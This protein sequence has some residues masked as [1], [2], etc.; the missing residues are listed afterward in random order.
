MPLIQDLQFSWRNALSRFGLDK[1]TGAHLLGLLFV[2]L[3]LIAQYPL[4]FGK[5][6][7]FRVWELERQVQ[8]A[9]V[10]SKR[11][12]DRNDGLGEE[13]RDLKTGFGALEERARVDLGMLKS[14]EIFYRVVERRTAQRTLDPSLV[15]QVQAQT[16]APTDALTGA[17]AK[18]AAGVS[19]VQT[20]R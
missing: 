4:W 12:R 9:K 2:C 20:I 18:P 15:P 1:V 3:I 10:E 8:T 17:H 16:D 13:V 14:D 19:D 6:G 11:V 5:G 7:W